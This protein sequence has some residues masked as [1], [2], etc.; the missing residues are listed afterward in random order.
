MILWF[1]KLKTI[2]AGCV[3][4]EAKHTKSDIS[5]LKLPRPKCL[6]STMSYLKNEFYTVLKTITR[7]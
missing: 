7:C 4:F 3:N 5:I 6:K 2:L 1:L